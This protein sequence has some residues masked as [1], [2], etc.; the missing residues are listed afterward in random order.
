ME[1]EQLAAAAAGG[2]PSARDRLLAASAEPARRIAGRLVDDRHAV[3]DVVQDALVEV[4]GSIGT[5]REPVAYPR[6]LALVVRKHA[7]RHRRRTRPTMLLDL[8][9]DLDPALVDPA[10]SSGGPDPA[11]AA[12]RG[13]QVDRVRRA[14]QLTRDADRV[15]LGLRYYGEWSDAE[16]AELLGISRGAVRKRLYDARGR[17]RPLLADSTDRPPSTTTQPRQ[18]TRPREQT[19]SDATTDNTAHDTAATRVMALFGTTVDPASAPPPP[20]GVALSAPPPGAVLGTGIKALDAVAPWPRGGTVDFLG[21]VGTGHLVILG[22]VIH[23]LIGVG[24]AAL[25]AVAATESAADHSWPG[26]P[27]LLDAEARPEATLI[28]QAPTARAAAA[29]DYAA[30]CASTL[31]AAGAQVLLAVDRVVAERVGETTFD[32][33]VGVTTAGGSVTGVRVAPHHPEADPVPD[34]AGAGAVTIT[35][36]EE[37]AA[38]RY[39]AIDLRASRSAVLEHADAAHREVAAGCRR[40]LAEAAAVRAYLEQPFWMAEEHTGVPGESFTPRE[41]VE[42]LAQQVGARSG[43][44]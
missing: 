42:G 6:W 8:V 25:I 34:W 15:L 28:V 24:P 40:V 33:R 17:L 29:L 4:F 39:P 35:S 38:H 36:L 27:R 32:G 41:A 31:A 1:L 37:L 10:T 2:D 20:A 19:M 5:L 21:P 11:Q 26:L 43:P 18:P 23:N 16:L 7:D 12:E 44:A 9:I 13:D 30:R 14:L 22:E 3:D